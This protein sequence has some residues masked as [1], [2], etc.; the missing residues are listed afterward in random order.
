MQIL[1]LIDSLG[2]GGAQRQMV[3]LAQILKEIGY[4][5]S[6]LVYHRADFFKIYLDDADISVFK[7]PDS[8][9]LGRII[10]TRKYIRKGNFDVVI[11]FLDTPNF[12]NCFAAIGGK[13]W[14][15]ITSERSAK[16]NKFHALRGK[17]LLWFQRYAD[18]IV[19]NSYNAKAMWEQFRPQYKEK[20]RVIYNPVLLPDITAEYIPKREGKLHIVVAASYQYLKNP[21]G[22]INA[23]ILMS[24]EE[25]SRLKVDWYGSKYFGDDKTN[26]YDQAISLIAEFNLGNVIS[27]NQPAMDIANKMFE[28]DVV[29]LFSEIEGLPNAICEG[30]MIGKPVIMSK[31]SDFNNLV[32]GKNGYL[33]EWNN[34]ENI[35]SVILKLMHLSIEQLYEMGLHSKNKALKLFSR[36]KIINLWL[37]VISI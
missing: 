28:A 25:R 16:E 6:F 14:K 20:L 31:V 7:L 1:L 24:E 17:I 27:L 3:T 26:A 36:D 32:D 18:I 23:L 5:V 21:I 34:P 12:L 13:K 33:C 15:V 19:A 22:L 9:L 35:K 10:N 11:S 37:Q 2:S 4:N 30:M 29:G 8:N